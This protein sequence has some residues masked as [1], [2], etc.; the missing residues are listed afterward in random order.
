M[1]T[2]R[3][4]ASTLATLLAMGGMGLLAKAQLPPG[5]FDSGSDG[6]LGEV[7]I[8]NN[9][10]WL[11]PPDGKLH[12]ASFKLLNNATLTFIRN[13]QNTP[14][15]L[16]S[17]GEV[18]LEGRIEVSGGGGS[19][20]SPGWGGPGGFDGGHRGHGTVPPGDGQGPGGGRSGLESGPSTPTSAG[21]GSFLNTRTAAST[22]V[23]AIYGNP[24]L[25]P[26]IGG[27]GGGGTPSASG[28]GGG[29]AVLVASNTRIVFGP[30]NNGSIHA[31]GG[32]WGTSS[33][34]NGGSGGAVKLVAPSIEGQV[35]IDVSGPVGG[36]GRIRVDALDQSKVTA[37]SVRPTESFSRGSMMATG[38]EPWIPRLELVSVAGQP[39]PT[40]IVSNGYIL[41][42]NGS[43][44]EQEVVVRAHRFGTRLPV[45]VV[46]QPEQGASM[47]YPLEIDNAAAN[48]ATATVTVTIPANTPV[49]VHAWTR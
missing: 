31:L 42:P 30:A 8:T 19:S 32:T 9:T 47:A 43:N 5:L 40:N 7:V 49:R 15:Y 48:P 14:V 6:S 24:V 12:V 1:N 17:Q 3:M 25:I 18:W 23:G 26:L 38:L 21:A 35:S 37:W 29:G 16:L 20:I 39:M 4:K 11:M 46:V 44:P 28:G 13:P 41:L 34:W 2:L 10:Q 45:E 22:N 33:A 36:S 27:S